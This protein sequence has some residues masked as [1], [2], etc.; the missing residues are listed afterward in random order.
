[1]RARVRLIDVVEQAIA[2]LPASVFQAATV[3]VE[4]AGAPEVLA[5]SSQI[6]QVVINLIANAAR[7]APEGKKVEIV[8]RLGGTAEG[9]AR[10]EVV[11]DG[12]GIAPAHIDR[13]FEPFFT[14]RPV[15]DGRGIGIGLAISHS[16]VDAHGGTLT[17]TSEV[18]KGSTFRVELPAAPAGA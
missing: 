7:A 2:W 18:G 3:Q 9:M 12:V 17:V 4:N 1:P 11:D 5:A 8:I 6:E 16:I 10:V 13:I 14:T 15:G